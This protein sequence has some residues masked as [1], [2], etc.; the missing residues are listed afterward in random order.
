MKE[1]LF[2]L[3]PNNS[4]STLLRKLI[5]RS[6]YSWR[7]PCE[8][9]HVQGYVGPSSRSTGTRLLWASRRR[10]I[11]QFL[12]PVQ[13]NWLATQQ[14][15]QKAAIAGDRDAKTLVVSSPPFLL[16][17]NELRKHFVKPRFLIMVRDPYAAIEGIYRRRKQQPVPESLCYAAAANHVMR[18]FQWQ[19]KNIEQNGGDTLF[20]TYEELCAN[21][22]EI[23]SS[24][25][26][27]TPTL[28]DLDFGLPVSVK[29]N[30]P[31]CIK[32]KNQEQVARI[33]REGF[34]QINAVLQQHRDL[35]SYFNYPVRHNEQHS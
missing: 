9:Q 26:K 34:Q 28:V 15:W 17:M 16:L 19:R 35:M 14:A 3:A 20:F 2:I 21:P 13:Y 29:G 33:G 18:C 31:E 22:V 6:K 27:L 23:A 7:L 8:G 30:E 11:K 32:N 1:H 5:E 12:E 24:I 25:R 4:G 10:W